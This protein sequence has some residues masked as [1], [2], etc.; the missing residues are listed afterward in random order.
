MIKATNL[1]YTMIFSACLAFGVFCTGMSRGGEPGK[2]SPPAPRPATSEQEAR[3]R[4]RLLHGTISDT[5]LIVHSRYYREDEGLPIPAFALKDVFKRLSDRNGVELRWLAVDAKA[6]NIDHNPKDDF[7]RGAVEALTSGK[8]E[9]E[10]SSVGSY[11]YVG[12][13]TLTSECLKCH[14]PNRTSNKPRSAGLVISIPMAK[15]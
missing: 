3:E 9:F 7:E 15:K 8:E 14:M 4:A 11:R 12:L 2:T 5:L 13:I 1:I 6:M 10:R